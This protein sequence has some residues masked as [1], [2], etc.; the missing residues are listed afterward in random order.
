MGDGASSH[1]DWTR[2][3]FSDETSI[4]LVPNRLAGWGKK[5]FPIKTGRHRKGK[6]VHVWAAISFNSKSEPF[7]F[8]QNL[9]AELYVKILSSNLVKMENV[10][11]ESIHIFQQDGDSK[12]TATVTKKWLKENNI[13]LLDWP[14][15][16]P[17][18]NPIE[19]IWQIIKDRLTQREPKNIE[20]LR[21]YIKE[22]WNLLDQRTIQKCYQSLPHRLSEC[23]RL[24]GNPIAY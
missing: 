16:S 5:G 22:E 10:D 3:V 12:H 17:D 19:N 14:P 11:F 15:N 18:L 24:N 4:Q 7:I 21:R 23:I 2:I 1:D 6:K 13:T 8:E 9:T 20:E